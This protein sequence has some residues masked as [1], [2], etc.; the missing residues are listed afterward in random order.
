MNIVI[1]ENCG[2]SPKNAFIERFAAQLI[3]EEIPENMVI[4][5]ILIEIPGSTVM[6]GI[7]NLS[8]QKLVDDEIVEAV[9]FDAV[10]H[11]KKARDRSTCPYKERK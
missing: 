3:K 2:N 7:E 4:D 5:N 8:V 10:S 11:G 1:D 6:Y 9:I